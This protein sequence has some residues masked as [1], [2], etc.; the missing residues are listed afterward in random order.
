MKQVVCTIA[1][2]V[3]IALSVPVAP[4]SAQ[5]QLKDVKA[6][7]KGTV[8]LGLVG[9]ELGLMIPSLARFNKA[10]ALT[11]FPAVGATGGAIAGYFALDKPGREKG[12]VAALVVGMAGVVPAVLLTMRAVRYEPDRNVRQV[13]DAKTPE[14]TTSEKKMRD[15][16][17]AG[18]GLIR[19]SVSGVHMGLPGV[20]FVPTH[21]ST[22]R[23]RF[24]LATSNEF[25]VS[26]VSGN[27]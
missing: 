17:R 8:G 5:T 3:A 21:S 13:G 22:D 11:V 4:A 19:R 18:S 26:L 15:L 24:Q 25:N 23:E 6:S 14:L 27:F 7:P 16:A 10:W 1:M 20:T 2:A 9:A 12:S